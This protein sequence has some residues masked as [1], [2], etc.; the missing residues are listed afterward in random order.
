MI[1]TIKPT[2]F[3][4]EISKA[5]IE[6]KQKQALTQNKFIEMNEQM[7]K[8]IT[9]SNHVSTGKSSLSHQDLQP[10]EARP[11]VFCTR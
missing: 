6:R 8:L 5:L 2:F 10:L 3:Q 1:N 9:S 11:L 7:L 4:T